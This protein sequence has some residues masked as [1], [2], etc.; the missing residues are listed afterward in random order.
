MT[1]ARAN[2][3]RQV[4][5]STALLYRFLFLQFRI[6]IYYLIGVLYGQS[7]PEEPL[8]RGFAEADKCDLAIVLVSSMDVNPSL[9]LLLFSIFIEVY[10]LDIAL[11]RY[12]SKVPWSNDPREPFAHQ[13]RLPRRDVLSRR[14]RRL[15][16]VLF[17]L[18]QL[19]WNY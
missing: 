18:K 13:V 14:R 19:I 15:Y 16:E 17:L 7:V 2:S 12:A 4:R 5:P 11:L 1:P 3:P 9:Y 8:E 10:N 6:I